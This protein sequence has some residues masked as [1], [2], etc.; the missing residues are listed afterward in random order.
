MATGLVA[1]MAT[2]VACVRSALVASGEAAAAV[3]SVAIVDAVC[4]AGDSVM[5]VD[6]G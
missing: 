4:R 2:A 1:V 6:V 3:V 5:L